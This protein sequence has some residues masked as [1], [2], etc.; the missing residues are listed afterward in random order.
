MNSTG[1]ES[2]TSTLRPVCP[3]PPPSHLP[4]FARL[5]AERL[6]RRR[7]CASWVASVGHW[8]PPAGRRRSNPGEGKDGA[9][10][11]GETRD[12][13]WIG[14][15]VCFVGIIQSHPSRDATC[16]SFVPT[17]SGLDLAHGP[18]ASLHQSEEA[19]KAKK[20][21]AR[22]KQQKQTSRPR[23]HSLTAVSDCPDGQLYQLPTDGSKLVTKKRASDDFRVAPPC[24]KR[25]GPKH[26]PPTSPPPPVAVRPYAH[27]V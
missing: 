24:L 12:F 23:H 16:V 25:H 10:M 11:G 13:S 7:V 26:E 6:H 19:K 3:S 21:R 2:C 8:A 18:T 9:R 27:P 14:T 22:A 5:A 4:V 20:P 15:E 17:W 1:K